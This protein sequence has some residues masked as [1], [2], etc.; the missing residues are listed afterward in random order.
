[1]KHRCTVNVHLD[2]AMILALLENYGS[3]DDEIIFRRKETTPYQVIW[4]YG[5]EALRRERFTYW[6]AN[7]IVRRGSLQGL[8][9]DRAR[10]ERE[11]AEASL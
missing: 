11:R 1:M 3:S 8:L 5:Y 9:R 10:Y 4:E 2:E 6:G 7:G